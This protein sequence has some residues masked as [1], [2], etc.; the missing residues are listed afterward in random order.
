MSNPLQATRD[1]EHNLLIQERL[2]RKASQKRL[3]EIIIPYLGLVFIFVFF[4][5]STNGRF[6][7][8]VNIENLINQSF[9]LT[10]I[11]VGA[12]FVY[13]H[14]GKDMSIGATSG[15]GQ[16]ACASML[17]A[18]QPV[19]LSII[20][21]IIVTMV[22]ASMV[23]GISIKLNVPVFIGSM[24]V[25]TSFLGILQY[26]TLRGEVVVD[27]HKYSYMNNTMIKF[28]VIIAFVFIGIYLYRYTTFG[29]YNK[30]VG[31]N[32]ATST[33]AG[34]KNNKAILSAFLFMGFCV[35]VSAIFSFFRMGKVT[36]TTGSGTEFN[37][38]IAM[39]LGGV[40]MMGGDKTRFSSAIVGALS[41]TFLGNGL[42][43][44]GLLPSVINGV[45]GLLFIIIIAISYDRSAGKLIS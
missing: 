9:G 29:K 18:G 21:C 44:M 6:L 16:L 3:V 45:K 42:Q 23:A 28:F 34:V 32:P 30:A 41:I 10:I 36:G 5:I 38:M 31:G 11:A 27:Y 25:R 24:C 1:S 20:V 22:A 37:I 12:L 43:V 7:S 14:S 19:W 40:P 15:C 39:A 4:T 2:D 33:Q 26:V 8:P 17:L 35:G 13:A